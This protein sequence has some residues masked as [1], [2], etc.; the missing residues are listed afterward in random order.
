MLNKGLLTKSGASL[1]A[2]M[3]AR[4]L[5]LT[6]GTGIDPDLLGSEFLCAPALGVGA[7]AALA[8]HPA[9]SLGC[10]VAMLERASGLCRLRIVHYRVSTRANSTGLHVKI[11]RRAIVP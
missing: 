8:A 2:A 7:L 1:A 5:K 10:K 4:H 6:S 9:A 11:G 3:I